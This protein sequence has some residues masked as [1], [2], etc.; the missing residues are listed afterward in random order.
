MMEPAPGP[1]PPSAEPTISLYDTLDVP[2]PVREGTQNSDEEWVSLHAPRKKPAVTV[3]HTGITQLYAPAGDAIPVADVVFVHGLQGHPRKTWACKKKGNPKAPGGLWDLLRKVVPKEDGTSKG[4]EPFTPDEDVEYW[5]EELLPYDQENVRVLTYGYDSYVTKGFLEANGKSSI[6]A[7]GRS[8]LG[9][10]SRHRR[11]CTG[12]PIVFVAHSLGGLVVKQALI[13]AKKQEHYDPAQYDI[14]ECSSA[15]IFFGTPHRG[16]GLAYWGT[17][18]SAI[19]KAVQIDSNEKIIR[20]LV[21]DGSSKLEELNLDFNDVLNDRT[22]T[23]PLKIF[24][25]QEDRGITG[26]KLL[27]RKVHSNICFDEVQLT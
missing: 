27:S 12:R 13:E 14:Y 7:H 6:F 3:R 5:P 17:V 20:D 25:F 21:P 18:L 8:F 24:T 2:L 22:R 10:I 4:A 11:Q 9:A 1:N 15:I 23:R 16:S 19:A 26:I